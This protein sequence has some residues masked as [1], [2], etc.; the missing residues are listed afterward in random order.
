MVDVLIPLTGE[1]II[2]ALVWAYANSQD[3]TIDFYTDQSVAA[4]GTFDSIAIPMVAY[5]SGYITVVN[6]GNSSNLAIEILKSNSSDGAVKTPMLSY[7]LNNT[8]L[9]SA[10]D[11]VAVLP[12]YIFLKVYNYDTSNS[13]TFSLSL[14]L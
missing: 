1:Q 12:N 13:T 11:P 3:G 4:G 14:T 10:G 8:T 7:A 5:H 2:S 9:P 6:T